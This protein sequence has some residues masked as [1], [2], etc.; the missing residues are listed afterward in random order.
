MS[1]AEFVR[2]AALQYNPTAE[3]R[4][5]EGK[6]RALVDRFGAMHAQTLAQLD[7]TDAALS[8][9]LAHFAAKTLTK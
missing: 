9:A 7:R 4:H 3:R 1:I 6:L 5:E 2:R 8:A